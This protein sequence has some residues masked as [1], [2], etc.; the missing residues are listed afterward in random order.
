MT[1]TW[2]QAPDSTHPIPIRRK[3]ESRA[4]GDT[5]KQ[6]Q[7][8]SADPEVYLPGPAATAQDLAG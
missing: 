4:M 3:T 6:L 2:R 7:G 1:K 5:T 8:G